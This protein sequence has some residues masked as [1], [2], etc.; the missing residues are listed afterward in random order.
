MLKYCNASANSVAKLL[1]KL[2]RLPIISMPAEA[3]E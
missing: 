2:D 1:S 3:I